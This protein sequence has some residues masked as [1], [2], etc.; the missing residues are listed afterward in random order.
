MCGVCFRYSVGGPTPRGCCGSS[1]PSGEYHASRDPPSRSRRVRAVEQVSR[2]GRWVSDVGLTVGTELPVPDAEQC[3]TGSHSL[4]R[5]SETV[6]RHNPLARSIALLT[7]LERGRETG[8][9]VPPPSAPKCPI[10]IDPAGPE[11]RRRSRRSR[12][13]VHSCVRPG[14]APSTRKPC[15]RTPL[16]RPLN[17]D[18]LRRSRPSHRTRGNHRNIRTSGPARS[19][20]DLFALRTPGI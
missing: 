10:M 4:G 20:G 17:R 11:I 6:E 2:R 18:S 14:S 5:G 1:W 8:E 13:C 12:I 19:S 3:S 16:R 7:C 15:G 9:I